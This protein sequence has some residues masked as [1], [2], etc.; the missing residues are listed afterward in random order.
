MS[1]AADI[2]AVLS[3]SDPDVKVTA[4][5]E[6]DGS[7]IVVEATGQTSWFSIGTGP[8]ALLNIL[9]TGRAT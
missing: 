8:S 6:C 2:E 1:S 5:S 3:Y 4:K 9:L 7:R